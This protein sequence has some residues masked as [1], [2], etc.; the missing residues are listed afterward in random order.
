VRN[1]SRDELW[2]YAVK[3]SGDNEG[4]FI[5]ITHKTNLGEFVKLRILCLD[6][7]VSLMGWTREIEDAMKRDNFCIVCRKGQ[8]QETSLLGLKRH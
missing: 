8:W 3:E 4:T 2:T 1:A 5:A 6:F 7:L